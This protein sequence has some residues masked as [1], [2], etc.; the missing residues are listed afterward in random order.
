VYLLEIRPYARENNADR[1]KNVCVRTDKYCVINLVGFHLSTFIS[2]RRIFLL[3]FG[4][5][6]KLMSAAET[7]HCSLEIG[8]ISK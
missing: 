4:N 2:F 5:Q 8:D 7:V 3:D 1:I 6:C